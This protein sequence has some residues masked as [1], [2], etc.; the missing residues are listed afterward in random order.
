[1]NTQKQ[2]TN[3]CDVKLLN[4]LCTSKVTGHNS[5]IGIMKPKKHAIQFMLPREKKILENSFA[6]IDKPL[7]R[8][9]W[10]YVSE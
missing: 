4:H 2:T 9:M 1:M 6:S 3:V 8:T 7:I 10:D 5:E